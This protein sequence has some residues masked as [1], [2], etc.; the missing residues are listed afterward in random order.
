MYKNKKEVD[1]QFSCG[2]VW[3][4]GH[5]PVCL[6][7]RCH[8]SD[9]DHIHSGGKRLQQGYGVPVVNVHKAVSVRLGGKGVIN[10]FH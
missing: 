10:T 3:I 4:G 5:S 8:L 1:I 2:F 7:L 6:A 9:N